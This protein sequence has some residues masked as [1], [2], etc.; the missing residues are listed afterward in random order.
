MGSLFMQQRRFAASVLSSQGASFKPA[1]QE[2]RIGLTFGAEPSA[3]M[4]W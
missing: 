4:N 2:I 1:L 3:A